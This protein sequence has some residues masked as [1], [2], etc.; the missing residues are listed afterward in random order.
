MLESTVSQ[1]AT[2]YRIYT[3]FKCHVTNTKKLR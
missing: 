3:V 1:A 2:K